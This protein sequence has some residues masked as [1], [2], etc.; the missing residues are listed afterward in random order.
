MSKQSL[1]E[2]FNIEKSKPIV[3]NLND[4]EIFRDKAKLEELRSRI[5]QNLIDN[6]VNKIAENQSILKKYKEQQ[7]VSEE[8]SKT[9]KEF[10]RKQ[11]EMKAD[12][13][14]IRQQVPDILTGVAWNAK[15]RDEK[16]LEA[17]HKVAIDIDNMNKQ[18]E[19]LKET[20]DE[21]EILN[22]VKADRDIYEKNFLKEH[23]LFNP[24]Y[25]K[26]LSAYGENIN[27]AN[28]TKAFNEALT[29]YKTKFRDNNNDATK[30]NENS[31]EDDKPDNPSDFSPKE[32][33]AYYAT[34][35]G[36]IQ[37][38]RDGHKI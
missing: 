17:K 7:Q 28:R 26:K 23:P 24:I 16:I 38:M 10:K 2:A 13:D 14:Y 25:E 22:K 4:Y 12:M 11:A 36:I 1:T 21:M 35:P 8:Y 6:T 33:K 20:S 37:S 32:R 29:E 3:N 15:D 30:T 34:I 31:S 27:P 9:S 5:I 18:L 19:I